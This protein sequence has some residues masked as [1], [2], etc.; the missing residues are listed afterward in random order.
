MLKEFEDYK[1]VHKVD[2]DFHSVQILKGDYKDTIVT[3]GK[4]T[5]GKETDEGQMPL[6]FQYQIEETNLDEKELDEDLKFKN[7][8]GDL[9]RDIILTSLEYQKEENARESANSNIEDTSP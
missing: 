8:L 3:Y 4:V 5:I 2:S 7:H 9:L 1:L 6:K